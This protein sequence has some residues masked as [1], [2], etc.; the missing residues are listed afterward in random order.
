MSPETTL[1]DV[2]PLIPDPGKRASELRKLLALSLLPG[3]RESSAAGPWETVSG[4][5]ILFS[6]PHEVTH[7]R[8]G[9]E[10][11]AERGTRALAFALARYT[12]G[13]ALATASEQVGDPN[14]DMGNPYVARVQVLAG[15]SPTV[16]IH[17]MRPRGVDVC[18]GL[19][20][21]PALAQELWPVIV[22]EAVAGGLR[23]S[24]NWPF[25]ANPRTVTGQLQARGLRAVQIEVSYE[26][27]DE[28]NPAMTRAWSSLG[29][30]AHRLANGGAGKQTA[31][32]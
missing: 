24:L 28:T 20:P 17:M 18:V 27:F 10:K 19:G 8:D 22:E 16:D 25:A 29:R 6:A 26:C 23:V 5:G 15:L 12:N 3:N 4:M 21:V 9:A 32:H 13:A 30:A 14:W 1:L 31:P 7:M 11:V 2:V